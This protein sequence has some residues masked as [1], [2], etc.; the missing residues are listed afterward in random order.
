MWGGAPHTVVNFY[1]HPGPPQRGGKIQFILGTC[2]PQAPAKGFHPFR[3][4]N[5]RQNRCL[6]PLGVQGRSPWS[7]GR[8]PKVPEIKTFTPSPLGE[9]RGG[10]IN[11]KP[12]VPKPQQRGFT[13][14][15]PQNKRQNRCLRPLGVQGRS[16][17]SGVRGQK[18]TN[19]SPK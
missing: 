3:S 15:D 13:P 10:G 11:H 2:G 18:N 9:G 19:R 4:P 7:G 17:W 1:P 14:L 8:G 5:K 12:A 16:P 6:R